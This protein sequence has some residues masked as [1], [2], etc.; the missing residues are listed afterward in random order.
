MLHKRALYPNFYSGTAQFDDEI[1]AGLAS[2]WQAYE[3]LQ[4]LVR[5]RL[6]SSLWL[7]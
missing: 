4:D 6:L 5:S 1:G 7:R 3:V 2:K